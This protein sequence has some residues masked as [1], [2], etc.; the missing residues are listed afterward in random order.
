MHD[1]TV[2]TKSGFNGLQDNKGIICNSF[3]KCIFIIL[4]C[5]KKVNF[6]KQIFGQI[7]N[8]IFVLYFAN[9]MTLMIFI[10]DIYET[11]SMRAEL[12]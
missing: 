1:V 12:S 7:I 6:W 4:L 5:N 3:F 9:I 8:I 2:F 10:N 11:L